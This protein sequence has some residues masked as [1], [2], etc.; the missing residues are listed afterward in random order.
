MVVCWQDSTGMTPR[1]FDAPSWCCVSAKPPRSAARPVFSSSTLAG[2][3]MVAKVRST[4]A[5]PSMAR[6][7]APSGDDFSAYVIA[8]PTSAAGSPEFT[9]SF[10]LSP[11]CSARGEPAAKSRTDDESDAGR[12]AQQPERCCSALL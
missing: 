11:E 8:S 4:S 9:V 10:R 3:F 12:R 1:L 7:S 2:S 6:S 5:H